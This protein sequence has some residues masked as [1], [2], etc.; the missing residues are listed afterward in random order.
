VTL[1]G[2]LGW[3]TLAGVAKLETCWSCEV[4]YLLE[5]QSSA[6]LL[7]LRTSPHHFLCTSSSIGGGGG[8]G[9]YP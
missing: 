4:G 7:E 2:E 5:V 3:A 1:V 6:D 9:L 8:G